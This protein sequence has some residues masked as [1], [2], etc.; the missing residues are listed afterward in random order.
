MVLDCIV[1][2]SFEDVSDVSPLVSLVSVK[3]VQD[4][5]LLLGPVDVPLDH[6]VKMVMPSF[7]ALLANTSWQMACYDSPF[8]WAINVDE[9]EQ[10]TIFNISPRSL[11][12]SRV[13]DLLPPMKALHISPSRQALCYSL[14]VLALVLF[15]CFGKHVV[16]LFSPMAFLLD[17]RTNVLLLLILGGSSLVQVGVELLVSDQVLLS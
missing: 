12:Q 13:E 7:P 1:C 9:M 5:F 6:G 10:Q 3:Q 15:H 17:P 2:T 16:F 14:P 11:D 4:P 8:L